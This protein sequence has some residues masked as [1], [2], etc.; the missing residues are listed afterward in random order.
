MRKLLLNLFLVALPLI[1]FAQPFK[2]QVNQQAKK[3]Q[4]ASYQLKKFDLFYTYLNSLYI[5]TIDNEQVVEKAI[6]DILADLDPHSR[7]I[8]S[9]EMEQVKE[10]F[11][12]KFSGI[13]VQISTMFDSLLVVNVIAGGPSETVGVLPN[14]RIVTVNDENIVGL[15]QMEAVKLLRGPRGSYVN[16]GVARRGSEEL[17]EF[18][19]KRDDIKLESIDAFYTIAPDVGYIKVNRFAHTTMDEFIEA[20]TKLNNPGALILDLRGNGGGLMN[21]AIEIANIFLP[22]GAV[23]TSTEGRVV[24]SNTFTGRLRPIYPEG[25]LVVLMDEL[26]A[27]AS[28]IVAGAIQDWDRGVIVGRRSFG[29]G[30]VQRQM[31]LPDGSAVNITI[32]QYLTPT[33]RAI[34]RPFTKGDK[35]GYYDDMKERFKSDYVDSL[36]TNQ[37]EQYK[38]LV[39]GKTVYGGGGIYPDYYVEADTTG[40]SEYFFNLISKGVFA[41]YLHSYMDENRKTLTKEYPEFKDYYF[42]FEVDNQMIE[43]LVALGEKNN[44]ELNEQELEESREAIAERLKIVITDTLYGTTEAVLMINEDDKVVQKALEVIENWDTKAKGIALSSVADL[45]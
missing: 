39:L 41:E 33:G 35:E 37:T 23:I 20:F 27:S 14:D 45:Q 42:K 10:S 25:K 38:T 9:E 13:G 12:G 1:L 7:Y 24:P 44:V 3:Q 6:I 5:D 43:D 15:K 18:R 21:Q 31:P 28:E 17:I 36:D 29:K 4:S 8:S 11:D 22:K 30:L 16:V 26:S 19:I 40:N 32:A 2:A 34:Q